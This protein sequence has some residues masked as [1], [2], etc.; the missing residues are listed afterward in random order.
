MRIILRT[1]VFGLLIGFSYRVTC[2]IADE[3]VHAG[4]GGVIG[5]I[6]IAL[7]TNNKQEEGDV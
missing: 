5:F 1:L 6:A 4:I 7:A 3:P 2:W